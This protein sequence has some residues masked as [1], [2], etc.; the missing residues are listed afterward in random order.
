MEAIGYFRQRPGAERNEALA[1][2]PES[3]AGFF[4]YCETQGFQP[5]ATFIDGMSANGD[6]ERGYG[7]LCDFLRQ[8]GRGFTT[9]VVSTIEDLAERPTEAV[10]RLVELE[11]LGAKVLVTEAEDLERMEGAVAAWKARRRH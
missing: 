10:R 5:V 2:L 6:F 9:V 1:T 7:Q 8:P 3:E 11:Y 4:A